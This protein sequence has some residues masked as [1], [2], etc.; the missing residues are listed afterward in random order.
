MPRILCHGKPGQR[1]SASS[2]SRLADEQKLALDCGNRFR[3]FPERLQIHATRELDDHVDAVEDISQGKYRLPKRQ[4]WPRGKL[5][6][7][8][9]P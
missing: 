3:V 5:W 1:R 9:A 4:G 8:P 7:Q 6:R 2:P